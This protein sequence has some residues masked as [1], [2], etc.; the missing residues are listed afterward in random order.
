M[1][2][3]RPLQTIY[4]LTVEL[5]LCFSLLI[6]RIGMILTLLRDGKSIL[7]YYINK[8]IVLVLTGNYKFQKLRE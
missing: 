2:P 5:H 7:K 3:K 1:G 6:N 8:Y 4:E